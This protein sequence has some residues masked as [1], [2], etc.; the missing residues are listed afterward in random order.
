MLLFF[1]L[2]VSGQREKEQEEEQIW[3]ICVCGNNGGS[4]SLS[5]ILSG[6][7]GGA[8]SQQ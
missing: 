1:V 3:D 8:K 4:P 2:N 5:F 7:L 6:S